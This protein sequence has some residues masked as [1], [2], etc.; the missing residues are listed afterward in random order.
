M[1]WCTLLLVLHWLAFN[2]G[3]KASSALDAKMAATPQMPIQPIYLLP[4]AYCGLEHS[5]RLSVRLV[6][7]KCNHVTIQ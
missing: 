3:R 6:E 7:S 5:I 2:S 1:V 4:G